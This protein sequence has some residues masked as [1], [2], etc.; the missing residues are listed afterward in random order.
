[1]SISSLQ[2]HERP[3]GGRPGYPAQAKVAALRGQRSQQ[4]GAVAGELA[5]QTSPKVEQA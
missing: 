3:R 1:M 4:H 2:Q 5:S